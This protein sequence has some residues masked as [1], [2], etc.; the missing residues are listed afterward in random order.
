MD[1]SSS[2]LPRLPY[3]IEVYRDALIQML[4]DIGPTYGDTPKCIV[5]ASSR[6]DWLALWCLYRDKAPGD[7]NLNFKQPYDQIEENALEFHLVTPDMEVS[8]LA[9]DGYCDRA[10]FKTNLPYK[11]SRASP[12]RKSCCLRQPQFRQILTRCSDEAEVQSF[13]HG[14]RNRRRRNDP[15]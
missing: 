11:N 12:S 13:G 15:F 7:H 6:E 10:W 14:I 4:D 3:S 2:A 8:H 5:Y 9:S 1:D